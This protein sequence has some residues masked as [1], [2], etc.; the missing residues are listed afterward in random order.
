M[1][2][3]NGFPD[4]YVA[5]QHEDGCTRRMVDGGS[6]HDRGDANAREYVKGVGAALGRAHSSAS[7]KCTCRLCPA[8]VVKQDVAARGRW[9][10]MSR[11]AGQLG[12]SRGLSKASCSSSTVACARLRDAPKAEPGVCSRKPRGGPGV[13]RNS[14]KTNR[15]APLKAERGPLAPL[16]PHCQHGVRHDSTCIRQL[17]EPAGERSAMHTATA[18]MHAQRTVPLSASKLSFNGTAHRRALHALTAATPSA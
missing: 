8:Q 11:R 4:G 13:E 12:G 5:R 10:K 3:L 6:R 7:G 14:T 18:A 9:S 17:A 2:M 1:H 15:W 16:S